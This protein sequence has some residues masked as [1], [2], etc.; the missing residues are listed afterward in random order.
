MGAN[1]LLSFLKTPLPKFQISFGFNLIFYFSGLPVD[2][3]RKTK[4]V[5]G[6]P[7]FFTLMTSLA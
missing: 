5:V 4:L 7:G 6:W 3:L 1:E 2:S